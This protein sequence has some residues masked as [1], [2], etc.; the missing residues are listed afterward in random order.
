MRIYKNFR[1]N[2]K[3]VL[4]NGNTLNI[5]N[6]IPDNYIDLVITSPP[7][8]MGREYD[9]S[10]K[11]EYFI[12]M[13][14]KIFPE[15]IRVV[16]D[17]GSICWQVGYHINEN[18]VIPLDYLIFDILKD[19]KDIFLK[20][21]IIWHY[22]HG[23]HSSKRFSGRHEIVLWFTKNKDNYEFNLD[24]V[25]IPQ[26][27]PGKRYYKGNRKGQFSG[28]PLGKNPSDVWAIPNINANHIEKTEHP[29]QFPI[30]LVQKLILALSNKNSYVLDPF[31]GSGTTGVAALISGRRFIGS[32]N[33][34]KYWKIAKNRCKDALNGDAKYRPYNKPILEP[35][36][37]MA[38]ARKPS[39]FKF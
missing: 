22:G 5:L 9:K 28:N 36:F 15:I 18:N 7:Y 8:C 23:L 32:D 37:N 35:S 34:N 12:K 38:V 33:N 3:C 4:Y 29:C 31:M 30:A 11:V 39:Y 1:K 13:H 6:K 25:R 21:R 24:N 17:S 19:Y 27:Y 10:N 2:V 14:K 26:K 16:K 20:N